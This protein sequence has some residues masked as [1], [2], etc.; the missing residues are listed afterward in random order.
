MEKLPSLIAQKYIELFNDQPLLIRSPGRVNLIGEHTDYNQGFVL[1]AAIDRAIYMAINLRDDNT[2]NMMAYDKDESY[3]SDISSYQKSDLGWPNYILGVIDE[4]RKRDIGLRGF[5]CVFGGNI[6]IGSGL[7][8]SAALEGA[9]SLT[10]NHLL[11]S[12]LDKLELVNIGQAAEHNFAGLRCGIMDQYIN[13]FGEKGSVLRI[14]CRSN[15]YQRV[16]F[17]NQ[18]HKIVLCDTGV[19]HDL[20]TSEY[21]I[22][23][24]QCEAGVEVLKKY[25][26]SILSLRD[27]S[28]YML[29]QHRDEM[30]D[31]IYKRCAFIIKENIRVLNGCRDLENGDLSTFGKRMFLSHE[32][33]ANEYQVS[34]KEL[35]VLVEIASELPGVTGSRMMGGG[36]GGCTINLVL[37]DALDD[38]QNMILEKYK[39]KTG[40]ETKIYVTSIESGAEIIA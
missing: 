2:I 16:P 18:D 39:K 26:N 20:A 10:M 6:P 14:D 29:D 7:S 34:C 11:Q 28:H 30:D 37:S 32:G 25:K 8:S 17:N 13:I 1:P 40:K 3:T 24:G 33:L 31:I 12:D 36:F 27:V 22:R 5:N 15:E 38:F 35:D 4:F 19:H 9:V 23:R 21:N